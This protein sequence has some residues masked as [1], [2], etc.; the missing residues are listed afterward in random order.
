MRVHVILC[1]SINIYTSIYIYVNN[2]FSKKQTKKTQW[3]TITTHQ[4]SANN[5]MFGYDIRDIRIYENLYSNWMEINKKGSGFSW[6]KWKE[7]LPYSYRHAYCTRIT[8]HNNLW[9][10]LWHNNRN[11]KCSNSTI[12]FKTDDHF[13]W[14]NRMKVGGSVPN[15]RVI[16]VAEEHRLLRKHIDINNRS[17]LPKNKREWERE[18]RSYGRALCLW[19]SFQV[20]I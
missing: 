14:G 12:V 20:V 8:L 10:T 2:I 4:Q 19:E 11:N 18:L 9:N 16:S 15:L 17:Y 5:T 1:L 3:Q 13:N 6:G 7:K